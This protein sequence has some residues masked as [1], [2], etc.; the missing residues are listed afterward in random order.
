MPNRRRFVLLGA[1]LPLG[2]SVPAVAQEAT[3]E[4][5]AE[6]VVSGAQPEFR[7][8]EPATTGTISITAVAIAFDAPEPAA[9]AFPVLFGAVV[10]QLDASGEDFAETD[11]PAIGDRAA[12]AA[13]TVPAD[14][15]YGID[16][17]DIGVVGYQD[18]NAILIVVA[19]AIDGDAIGD[20]IA[21]AERV[22]GRSG[23]HSATPVAGETVRQDGAFA[24]LPTLADVPAGMV[25]FAEGGFPE[26][27]G[28]P[29]P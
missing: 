28:T 15:S 1:A 5:P 6:R 2:L 24:V 4:D 22:A 26:D 9:D 18:A 3:P 16:A 7:A 11:P 25:I 8:P 21:T 17:F 13:G 10:G 20:A 14:P 29:T 27:A 12:A 19:T 23:A